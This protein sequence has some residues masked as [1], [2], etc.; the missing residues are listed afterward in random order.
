MIM[1]A[2][3]NAGHKTFATIA[4]FFYNDDKPVLLATCQ[5]VKQM[6]RLST[7]NGSNTLKDRDACMQCLLT[8][9]PYN[10]KAICRLHRKNPV[11]LVGIQVDEG[12]SS[13]TGCYAYTA[14]DY[15]ISCKAVSKITA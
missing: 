15:H 2:A 9:S 1:D 13:L 7:G 10:T 14:T 4:G 8:S 5:T 3:P 6:D 12:R 11:L